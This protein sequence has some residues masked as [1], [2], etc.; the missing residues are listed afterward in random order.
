[1]WLAEKNQK[2]AGK[3]KKKKTVP[4]FPC[5]PACVPEVYR[6]Q[7]LGWGDEGPDCWVGVIRVLQTLEVVF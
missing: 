2:K 7:E 4:F 6:G 5:Y 1:M 3:K